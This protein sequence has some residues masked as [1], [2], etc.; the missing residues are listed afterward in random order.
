MTYHINK[1][2]GAVL[3]FE[4]REQ[5]V[6]QTSR[7][8]FNQV[9][10]RMSLLLGIGYTC[11]Y[12]S[13]KF[14]TIHWYNYFPRYNKLSG[15]YIHGNGNVIVYHVYNAT[16]V[17]RLF[18]YQKPG[19]DACPERS[20]HVRSWRWFA[21]CP[22]KNLKSASVSTTFLSGY[23]LFMASV[24]AIIIYDRKFHLTPAFS[25][26]DHLVAHEVETLS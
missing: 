22:W 18:A 9:V 13:F 8:W 4:S 5:I 25:G 3:I 1:G 16:R 17:Q 7:L 15:F 23:G 12:G 24:I 20:V 10:I 21:I 2:F 6:L 14:N 19:V 26:H 11:E